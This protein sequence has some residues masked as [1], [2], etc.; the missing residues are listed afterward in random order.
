ML[1]K[2]GNESEAGRDYK[3]QRYIREKALMLHGKI[4]TAKRTK[5]E[6]AAHRAPT[7]AL[8]NNE[9]SG[10]CRMMLRDFPL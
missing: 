7:L 9:V 8:S 1:E 4:I 2:L 5:S 6:S 3:D 10:I